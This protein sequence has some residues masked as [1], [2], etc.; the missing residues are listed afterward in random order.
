MKQAMK[1]WAFAAILVA[2][3]T[4]ILTPRAA[5]QNDGTI[6]G[7]LLDVQ[8]KPWAEMTIQAV[9]DQGTKS[10][11]KTD[12]DG[13][14]AIHN[15]RGG[16]YT[17]DIQLPAPNKPYEVQCRVQ[18]GQATDV[19]VN[20]KD[21]VAKQGTEYQEQVKKQAE[22]KQKFEGMKEHF[23]AGNALLEQVRTAKADLT[24]AP[25][26]QRD[27]AKQ[28]LADLSGQAITEFQT[29]QKSAPEKDPNMHLLWAK[30]GESYDLAGRNDDAAQAY[31]QAITAK[32]EVP[33]Y[34]NNLGNVL[35]RGGKIDDARA[36][37][38][39]SAE[40]D[41]PNAAS[42]WRNFG[43]SLY[44]AGRLKEAVE[45]LKKSAELDPKNAQTW[46]LLGAAL[47]G[48]METKQVGQKLEFIIQPGTVEAY[49]KA[50]ELDPTG[51]WGIQAKQ[52]LEGLQQIAPGID[53]KV[54]VKK[55]K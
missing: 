12:K 52:G 13:N 54:N 47:V 2:A 40:L 23:T 42:A 49:Q 36:A 51:T 11:T 34:Y 35:A 43:I 48:A 15:L 6:S 18:A 24:K 41:P 50:V 20:F 45:P 16:V 31:Q 30:L 37:Y 21:I 53:T 28:K 10:E 7:K 29:A 44:N 8:G 46:Y 22:E 19:S 38:T 5:A 9:S 39:K 25:A 14:Y 4:S 33:A 32:P 3:L 17:V 55:K 1:S 26:D 27:A